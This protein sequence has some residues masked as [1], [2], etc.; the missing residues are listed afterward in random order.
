MG[1]DENTERRYTGVFDY[2]LES[3]VEGFR[4]I[5]SKPLGTRV[6]DWVFAPVT[7]PIFTMLSFFDAID[8]LEPTSEK[9]GKNRRLYRCGPGD[10]GDYGD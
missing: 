10:S 9:D 2:I 3:L 6:V 5:R 7:V 8:C 4:D 1:L